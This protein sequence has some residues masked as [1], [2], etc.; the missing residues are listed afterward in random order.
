MNHLLMRGAFAAIGFW[1]ATYFV[2]GLHFEDATTLFVAG[3]TLGL[4]NAVV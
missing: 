1:L 2:T 4:M 3:L